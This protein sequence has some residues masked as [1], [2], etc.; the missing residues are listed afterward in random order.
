M[1]K[2]LLQKRNG[3]NS[4]ELITRVNNWIGEKNDEKKVLNQSN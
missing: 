2:K 3:E 4:R 1:Q